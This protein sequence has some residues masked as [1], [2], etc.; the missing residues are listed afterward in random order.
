[1]VSSTREGAVHG[2][3]RV[4]RWAPSA[5]LRSPNLARAVGGGRRDD[6]V[7]PAAPAHNA[8]H[9]RDVRGHPIEGAVVVVVVGGGGAARVVGVGDAD[10]REHRPPRRRC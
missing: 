9:G 8:G 1:M 5:S 7:A 2:S 10:E 6:G 4:R 3:M